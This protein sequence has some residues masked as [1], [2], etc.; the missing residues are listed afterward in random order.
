[1]FVR[2]VLA[3]VLAVTIASPGFAGGIDLIKQG[4]AAAAAGDQDGALRAYTE[5]IGSQD[6]DTSQL[7]LAYRRRAGVFGYLGENIKG[8][9]DY[10]KS[11]ELNPNSGYAYS[12]RG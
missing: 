3:L 12:L 10:S 7:A 9:A 4:E 5:A 2:F 8:I 6:L 1:M 11:L